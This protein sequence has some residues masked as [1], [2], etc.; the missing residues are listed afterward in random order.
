[1]YN[2]IM[3]SFFKILWAE[4][5]C[6]A[7]CIWRGLRHLDYIYELRTYDDKDK[8]EMIAAMRGS[9]FTKDMRLNPDMDII[10]V[11]YK[12]DQIWPI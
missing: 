3:Y 7:Y 4:I 1:M 11:F 8:L 5:R 2:I 12:K 6:N 9:L 10:K